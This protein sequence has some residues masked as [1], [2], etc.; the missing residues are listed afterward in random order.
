MGAEVNSVKYEAANVYFWQIFLM[1]SSIPCLR[2]YF[3]KRYF[4][5]TV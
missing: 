4:L 1:V 5:E 3:F 2:A